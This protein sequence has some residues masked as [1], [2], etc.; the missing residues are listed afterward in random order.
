MRTANAVS[1]H[2]C[3]VATLTDLPRTVITSVIH[4]RA[5]AVAYYADALVTPWFPPRA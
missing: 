4:D 5:A 1:S 3:N 2:S